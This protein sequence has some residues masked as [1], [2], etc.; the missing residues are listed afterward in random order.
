MKYIKDFKIFENSFEKGPLLS[1]VNNIDQKLL[2][3]IE[4]LIPIGNILEISCGNGSDAIELSKRG[5]N[6]VATDSSELYVK[7]VGKFLK[8]ILHDTRK[9][10]PFKDN[11]FDLVYSRLG[12][13]Y[14]N[15]EEL[16]KIFKEINRLTNKYL[17]ISV[18]LENGQINSGKV[19]FSKEKWEEIISKYF[20]ILSSE[21]KTGKL[22]GTESKWLE[23]V[24]EKL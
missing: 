24:S 20:I 7:Y 14:F 11:E 5:Y 12:L 10:F 1:L 18:K 3:K 2:R 8:C 19:I 6:V 15:E 23:I 22:Y 9:R 13:H 21:V 4:Q 16:F 17:L